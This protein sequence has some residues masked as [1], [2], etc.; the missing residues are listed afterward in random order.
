MAIGQPA[1]YGGELESALRQERRL[2]PPAYG[3]VC[4]REPAGS[5][6]S[7]QADDIALGVEADAVGRGNSRQ[8]RH[9]HDVAGDRDNELG[10]RGET[11]LANGNQVA[12]RRSL[13]IGV[14]R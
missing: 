14:G 11:K 9:G 4:W 8:A 7:E 1:R 13:E 12:A 2:E 6:R 10:A 5:A 3:S